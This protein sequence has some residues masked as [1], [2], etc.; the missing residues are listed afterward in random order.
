MSMRRVNCAVV[1]RAAANLFR[2]IAVWRFGLTT[3][4]TLRLNS[5]AALNPHWVED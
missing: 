4:S 3:H 2:A 1:K 5:M